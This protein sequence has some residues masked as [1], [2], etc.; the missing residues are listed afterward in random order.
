MQ[1]VSV[2]SKYLNL[3]VVKDDATKS[4]PTNTFI[5]LL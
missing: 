3:R 1:V 5:L 4:I 2:N